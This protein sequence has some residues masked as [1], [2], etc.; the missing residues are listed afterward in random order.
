M[1]TITV[2][3]YVCARPASIPLR[4]YINNSASNVP[5]GMPQKPRY[6]DGTATFAQGRNV[7]IRAQ[8]TGPYFLTDLPSN[9]MPN[10]CGEGTSVRIDTQDL[11]A[12]KFSYSTLPT[13]WSIHRRGPTRSHVPLVNGKQNQ[14]LSSA[15]LISRRKNNA[16]GRGSTQNADAGLSFNANNLYGSHTNYLETTNAK[17][18]TRNSGY[19]VPPKCRGVS[20]G[21][22]GVGPSAVPDY[23]SACGVNGWP[24]TPLL[25]PNTTI[26]RL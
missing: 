6:A 19:V 2:V 21:G 23:E 4:Q 25:A 22:P 12:K 14:I 11:S 15:E 26:N 17:R 13:G 24:V 16:I 7:Y 10:R 9:Q 1:S 20:R 3:H 5:M 8:A 18:R